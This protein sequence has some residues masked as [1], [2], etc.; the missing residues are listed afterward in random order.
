L[1]NRNQLGQL[2]QSNV[3][4]ALAPTGLQVALTANGQKTPMNKSFLLGGVL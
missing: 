3:G 1:R 4:Q 2:A